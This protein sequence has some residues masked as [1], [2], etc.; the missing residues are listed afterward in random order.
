MQKNINLL[1]Q[2]LKEHNFNAYFVS[3]KDEFLDEMTPDY[4]NRLKWLTGF[5]GSNGVAIISQKY[6]IFFTDGRYLSQAK[7]ELS[8]EFIILNIAK[9]KY[10]FS[11]GN[12]MPK[13]RVAYND[14]AFTAE[15]I[16]Q[17]KSSF[18]D[19]KIEL[20]PVLE[21]FVDDL[22]KR[23]EIDPL[24]A[25][26]LSNTGMTYQDKIEKNN[27]FKKINKNEAYFTCDTSSICWLLNIR[28]RDTEFSPLLHCY[29]LYSKDKAI[30]FVDKRKVKN[31]AG[32]LKL[33]NIQLCEVR[34][35][36]D[37]S[38][39]LAKKYSNIYLDKKYVS[40]FFYN[41]IYKNNIKITICIDP[42]IEQKSCKNKTEI[43]GM[44]KAHLFDGV[45]KTKFLHWLDKYPKKSELDE[46]KVSKKL[47][48]FRKENKEFLF[49][50][51]S[52]I[53]GFAENSAIIHYNFKK[54]E[55]KKLNKK[56]LLLID[57][58][59]QYKSGANTLGT[60]DVTRTIAIGSANKRQKEDYTLVLK[61]HIALCEAVFPKKTKGVHLDVLAR[62]FL[63]K[64]KKDYAHGTGHGV[65]SFLSVH[66][67]PQS[68][69]QAM[70]NTSLEEG[71]IISNEPGFYIDNQ[72]GI[73]IESLL[74]VVKNG[75]GSYLSFENLTL[76]PL[77]KNLIDINLLNQEEKKWL[78]DYHKK[79][80]QNLKG[81]VN[82]EEIKWLKE[83]IK[84]YKEIMK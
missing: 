34:T 82:K 46:E 84:F 9:L 2:K 26:K 23:G 13:L 32:Y 81:F 15:E 69:S 76:I 8:Q 3:S 63:W 73:R 28:G 58:G 21:S 64:N 68:I 16:F 50:S 35:F 38:K 43:L 59:G 72:Y 11:H 22:W 49:S 33:N 36:I 17:I 80:L 41:V 52:T 24:P 27:F 53:A 37:F 5:S 39:I 30:L 71:M 20:L 65:G 1:L 79:I 44:Q 66:E 31:I 75:S 29:F 12:I 60:T 14:K 70:I 77:D 25:Y 83:K 6:K 45:A 42:I 51:F 74:L 62:Q 78:F 55:S 47:L 7:K 48:E 61:G 19:E 10:W 4:L 67:P 56:S 18:P 54:G 57:S 40:D